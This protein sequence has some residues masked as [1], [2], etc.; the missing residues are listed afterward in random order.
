MVAAIKTNP[1]IF[2][3][4][5]WEIGVLWAKMLGDFL[6]FGSLGLLSLASSHAFFALLYYDDIFLSV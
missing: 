1:F 4:E 2:F 6:S 5:A 3:H